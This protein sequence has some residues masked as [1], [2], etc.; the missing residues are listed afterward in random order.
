MKGIALVAVVLTLATASW[1]QEGFTIDGN[2]KNRLAAAEAQKIYDATCAAVER[3]F[4]LHRTV[5]PQFKLVLG[6]ARSSV[7]FDHRELKLAKWNRY[8]F[9]QGVVM[10]AVQE[11]MPPKQRAEIAIRAVTWADSTIDVQQ[12]RK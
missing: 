7:D 8:L 5:R 12:L 2:G 9:A 4:G 3:E 1:T 10:L 6:A 11:M